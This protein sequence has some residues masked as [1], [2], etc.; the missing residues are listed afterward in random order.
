M[1]VVV[2]D[3][4]TKWYGRSRGILDVSFA[5]E[6]GEVFGFLGPNGAGKTTTIRT[7]LDFIRPTSGGARVFDL[8]ANLDAPRIHERIGFVPGDVALYRRMTG[9]ELF[10]YLGN[11]RGDADPAV[12]HAVAERLDLDPTV[13]I[14]R[15]SHG[16][17]QKVAL[18]QA[19]MHRP[20]LLVLDEPTQGLDP[21]IQQVFFEM[22]DE[23]RD[24]GRTVFLS[25]HVLPEVERMCD[26]VGIIREGRLAEVAAV[27]DLTARA[28]RT[29]EARFA[30]EPPLE[31]LRSLEGVRDLSVDGDVV[32]CRVVGDLDPFVK[33]LAAT[34]VLDLVSEKPSLEEIFLAFYGGG[35]PDAGGS[36][37]PDAARG[38]SP[39]AP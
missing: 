35:A 29:V 37:P 1:S 25:S 19:F 34:H 30:G 13:R 9:G 18:V 39:G 2:T 31:A 12:A 23:V 26:R 27:R 15:L 14:D 6:A 4:L 24:E 10:A 36:E 20:E 17:R 11:L 5:V 38:A 3:R 22:V 28:V 16:N 32:R 7:L 33:A 8:D 21:L